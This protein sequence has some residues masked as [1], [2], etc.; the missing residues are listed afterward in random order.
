MRYSRYSI[1]VDQSNKIEQS[2]PTVIAFSDGIF[3]A[4]ILSSAVKRAGFKVLKEKGKPRSKAQVILFAAGVYL[5]LRNYLEQI[6]RVKID[7]EYPGKELDIRAFL[8]RR[9]WRD[10]P[11]FKSERITF[12]RVGKKSPSDAKAR[13]VRKK[14]DLDYQKITAREL[15]E[16]L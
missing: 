7:T 1:E 11:L 2:G 13:E 8:L 12:G 3:H 10:E 4:I 5:L 15:L 9:I 16:I 6:E 14:K